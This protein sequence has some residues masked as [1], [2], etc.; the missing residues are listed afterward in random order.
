MRA[1]Y[2]LVAVLLVLTACAPQPSTGEPSASPTASA[3]TP[4]ATAE[5]VP[6]FE[7]PTLCSQVVL[8]AR[9]AA[10]SDDDIVLLGGPDGK[11]GDDYLAEP[12]PEQQL[13]GI[14]CIWGPNESENSSVTVSVAPLSAATRDEVVDDLA[15]T[16]GLNEENFDDAT[17]YWQQGDTELEPAILNVLRVDSW[18]SVIMT[19]G[20]PDSYA[21]AE[22]IAD[23][24]YALVYGLA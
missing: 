4:S 11:Y 18:I 6:V 2:S 9:T 10:W 8:L 17:I 7:M 22:D 1:G 14:T 20:G 21:E 16:Q 24:V 12:T 5:P 15:I 19:I 23:E 13:G 3:P